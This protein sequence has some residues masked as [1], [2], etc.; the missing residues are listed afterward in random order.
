MTST[1]EAETESKLARYRWNPYYDALGPSGDLVGLPLHPN[2]SIA[3]SR[4]RRKLHIRLSPFLQLVEWTDSHAAQICERA[5]ATSASSSISAVERT[6]Y[7]FVS[8]NDTP[9][10]LGSTGSLTT[11]LGS[12]EA[13]PIDGSYPMT[14]S[15][16]GAMSSI[17]T[18]TSSPT[19]SF[20]PHFDQLQK[21]FVGQ[22]PTGLRRHMI[23]ILAH[24]IAVQLFDPPNKGR[25]RNASAF[26]AL[27]KDVQKIL[28][29]THR[30]SCTR[31]DDERG[32]SLIAE[33]LPPTSSPVVPYEVTVYKTRV[34]ESG[35]VKVMP[36]ELAAWDGAAPPGP[37]PAVA[38]AVA[39]WDRSIGN[40]FGFPS[41]HDD[42]QENSLPSSPNSMGPE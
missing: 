16:Y 14:S 41:S 10:P 32:C 36:I 24:I 26:V 31:I 4:H 7:V 21:F 17:A 18:T 37:D 27:K 20:Q 30:V 9:T 5:S 35:A 42:P 38:V 6:L 40:T 33:N 1:E 15:S 29:F 28:A 3:P 39:A 8:P 12:P 11:F 2:L 22:V 23:R 13:F 25:M 19:H 34:P